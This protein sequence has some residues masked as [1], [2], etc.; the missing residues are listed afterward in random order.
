MDDEER[1]SLKAGINLS[2]DD[3]KEHQIVLENEHKENDSE[4]QISTLRLIVIGLWT[5]G[6]NFGFN[7]EFVLGTPL[8]VTL[9][10][11]FNS[12][13]LNSFNHQLEIN[14]EKKMKKNV[15]ITHFFCLVGWSTFWSYFSTNYWHYL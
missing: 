1:T 15:A 9:G 6:I 3:M 12:F 10:L 5:F 7:A 8:F 11:F 2:I 14:L 13:E 4:G